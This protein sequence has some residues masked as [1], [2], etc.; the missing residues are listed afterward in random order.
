MRV[1]V[2][3]PTYVRETCLRTAGGW[4]TASA[5]DWMRVQDD[6]CTNKATQVCSPTTQGLETASS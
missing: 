5:L 3:Q 6:L 1:H 2:S 4:P